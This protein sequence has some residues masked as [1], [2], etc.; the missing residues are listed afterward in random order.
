MDT[1]NELAAALGNDPDFANNLVTTLA[2]KLS[3]TGDTMSGILNMGTHKIT[4]L[5]D[6]TLDTDALNR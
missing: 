4:D 5:S 1:L 6:A 3:L 2:G